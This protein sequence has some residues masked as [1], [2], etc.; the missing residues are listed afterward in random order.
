MRARIVEALEN[1]LGASG[2]DAFLREQIH[3]VDDAWI[4]T[5][6]AFCGRL[7]R[8]YYM[9]AGVDPGFRVLEED[10][11]SILQLSAMEDT[12]EAAFETMPT[13]FELLADAWG[14]RDGRDLSARIERLYRFAMSRP[15]G[16]MWLDAAVG[17]LDA[18]EE[19]LRESPWMDELMRDAG[20]KLA[21]ARDCFA[22]ALSICRSRNGPD[23]YEKTLEEDLAGMAALERAHRR[24]HG[25]FLAA[26]SAHGFGSIGRRGKYDDETVCD[27][28]K[29][30]RD[31]G[32][33]W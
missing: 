19:A 3:G 20:L 9:A 14:G 22:E 11:A 31:R 2:D 15:E 24:G 26:L 30:L 17:A 12:L 10:Q 13:G 18:G 23:R 4:S 28:V 27:A 6:H 7:L 29:E 25:D 5:L 8:R 16:L 1:A 33:I 21:A 32:R